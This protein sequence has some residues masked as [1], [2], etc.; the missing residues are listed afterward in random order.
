[1]KRRP[2]SLLEV[3]IA[4]GIGAAVAAALIGTLLKTTQAQRK[5]NQARLAASQRAML[6]RYLGDLTR[7]ARSWR[8]IDNRLELIVDNGYRAD[9]AES[10][11]HTYTIARSNAEGALCLYEGETLRERLAP[12]SDVTWRPLPEQEP[13][14]WIICTLDGSVEYPLFV[15]KRARQVE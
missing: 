4:S 10:G 15:G 11:L 12:C 7:R 3:I 14:E 1:M 6:H 13:S 8:L 9:L 2:F 5:L